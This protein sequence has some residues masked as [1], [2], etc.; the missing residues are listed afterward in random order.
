MFV[1]VGSVIMIEVARPP[2]GAMGHTPTVCGLI[3]INVYAPWEKP[4]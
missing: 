3:K 1:I 2:K 4:S